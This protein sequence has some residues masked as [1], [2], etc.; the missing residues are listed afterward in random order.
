MLVRRR[1]P[2]PQAFNLQ[3]P[4]YILVERGTVRGQDSNPDRSGDTE[5]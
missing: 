3:V 1:V 2:P 4:I 5:T